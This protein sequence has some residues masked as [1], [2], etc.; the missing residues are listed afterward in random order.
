MVSTSANLSG[1]PN[2]NCPNKILDTFADDDMAYYDESLG[3]QSNPSQIIDLETGII[4][5][6]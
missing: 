3:D 2:I 6:E 4:I 5:R 1:Q